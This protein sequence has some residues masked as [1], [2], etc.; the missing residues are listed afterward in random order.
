MPEKKIDRGGENGIDGKNDPFAPISLFFHNELSSVKE[1]IARDN[2]NTFTIPEVLNHVLSHKSKM[3]RPALLLACGKVF[4]PINEQHI[5]LAAAIESLHNTT[6]LHDDVIDYAEV[7]HGKVSTNKKY[8]NKK[9]ILVGDFLLARSLQLI[10]SVDDTRIM[11]IM[12]DVCSSL[13]TGEVWNLERLHKVDLDRNN[14]VKLIIKKT[15]HLFSAACAMGAICSGA[16]PT[17][18][19]L[20]AEY[21][22]KFGICYQIIDDL[23]DYTATE[24]VLG[25][26]ICTDIREGI[27]T[28]PYIV[29]YEK[30][31]SKDRSFMENMMKRANDSIKEENEEMISIIRKYDVPSCVVEMAQK[32]VEEGVVALGKV[33]MNDYIINMLCTTLQ[34]SVSRVM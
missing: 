34:A 13:V 25:K 30:A 26:S 19:D 2:S 16:R 11:R 15:A 7:R 24:E 1:L 31:N 5:A 23:L 18:V 29:A 9:A 33:K 21:G 4:G 10:A 32:Y 14:A 12:A 22:L 27:V 20:L 3:V 6:L 28:I 8:G 17:E